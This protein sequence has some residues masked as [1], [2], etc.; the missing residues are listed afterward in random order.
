ML[1]SETKKGRYLMTKKKLGLIVDILMYVLL[2]VQMLYVFTGNNVHEF[3]GIAFFV[4]LLIHVVL[5]GWWFRSLFQTKSASRH[6]F[7]VITCLLL[8]ASIILMITSMG[9][10]RLLFPWFTFLG[11]PE[12]HRYLATA[13]LTLGVLHGGMHGIWRAK[14]KRAAYIWVSLAC[15]A[16]LS[17]GLFAVPYINRHLRTVDISGSEK[18]S[19]DKV[20]WN[21]KKPLV[22]YFTRMGNT[23][24]AE[25]VDAV[26]GASLL[27]A[28]G[29]L[30][31]SNQL[32]A[33]MV[34]DILDCEAVPITLTG[35]KYPSSYNDTVAVAGDEL[36]L[37]A[38]PAI[39]PVD[40]SD[41][42]SVILIYPLWWNSI[43]MPVATFLEE[44]DFS[45]KTIYLIITQGSSG[46]GNTISEIRELCPAADVVPGISIYCEDI[47][48][49][50]PALL[51]LFR[52]QVKP[53]HTQ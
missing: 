50:R 35:K 37:S 1:Q 22:V 39:E 14:K 15:I 34:C 40:V 49:A 52:A 28:D 30:T 2:L 10:S 18:V 6:F 29:E 26:S 3:L 17:I 42:D 7:D 8:L 21:G 44:N 45:G 9:V 53:D 31:G 36:K 5:R 11:E 43:P 38:R 27:I 20:T 16:A 13:V 41:Y 23:D 47:P 51:D 24:F 19:G 4:C 25:D 12:L 32:L 33:E 48:D 46:Y